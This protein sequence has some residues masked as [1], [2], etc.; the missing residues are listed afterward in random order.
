MGSKID[1]IVERLAHELPLT[2][3]LGNS[4]LKRVYSESARHIYNPGD[5]IVLRG[6]GFG[7]GI[8]PVGLVLAYSV[9]D[10]MV[11]DRVC[12]VRGYYDVEMTRD[13]FTELGSIIRA[14]SIE[15]GEVLRQTRLTAQDKWNMEYHF[16]T[17]KD[18]TPEQALRWYDDKIHPD[19]Y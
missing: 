7:W 9:R 13:V 16:M 5:V 15:T 1:R 6:N 2:F 3:V 10:H 18:T 14:R 19:I 11:G 4:L 8:R 12:G 17:L